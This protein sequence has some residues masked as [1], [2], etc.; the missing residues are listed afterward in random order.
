M[1]SRMACPRCGQGWVLEVH[2]VALHRDAFLCEECEALWLDCA[3]IGPVKFIDFGEY[4]EAHGRSG[5]WSE[6]VVRGPAKKV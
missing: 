3:S 2:I 5:L 4:M 6:L 1:E